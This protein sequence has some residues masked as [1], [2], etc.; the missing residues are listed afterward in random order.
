LP[1]ACC[2]WPSR[3]FRHGFRRD[4]RQDSTLTLHFEK[5]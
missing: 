3:R 4:G 2:S 5:N 1:L